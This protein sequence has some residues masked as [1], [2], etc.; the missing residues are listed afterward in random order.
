VLLTSVLKNMDNSCYDVIKDT[1]EDRFNGC[2]VYVGDLKN[3]GVGIAPYHDLD[4]QIPAGLK[5]EVDELRTKIISGEIPDTGCISF[6]QHCPGGL[7]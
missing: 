2:G 5:Q 1:K 6:P 4:S 7:Y 3:G